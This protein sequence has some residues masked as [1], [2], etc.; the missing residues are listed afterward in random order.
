MTDQIR[1][2]VLISGRVQ[3]VWYRDST[4]REA[5]ALGLTGWVKN[6]PD[7]RVAAVFEGSAETV[8]QIIHWCW[9]GPPHAR[10]DDISRIDKPA[11]G[12]FSDFSVH[13]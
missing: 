3:G 10:V 5:I 2:E 13:Y 4:R 6:L 9:D 11:V 7:G 8:E 12:E 1:T